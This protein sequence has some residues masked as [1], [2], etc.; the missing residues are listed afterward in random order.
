MFPR[1]AAFAAMLSVA[2][3]GDDEPTLNASTS[4]TT[5]GSPSTDTTTGTGPVST[6][7]SSST[8]PDAFVDTTAA[9]DSSTTAAP[10]DGVSA[11]FFDL[12]GTLVG[13]NPG[14]S[15]KFVERPGARALL[16]S[17]RDADIQLGLITT[18]PNNFTAQD[19]RD[20]L[21]EPDLLESFDLILMS[22]Q[23]AA[24]PK[25]DPAMFVEAHSL[26]RGAPAIEQ[27]AFITEE[28]ADIANTE[29]DPTLGAR[30]AGMLGVHLSDTT[31]S[32]LAD[33]TITFD[34]LLSTA[35]APWLGCP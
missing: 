8:G 24:S 5:T 4:T 2:C 7:S 9:L 34:S 20:L 27:T 3:G 18:V 16:D 13:D 10:C 12:G 1:A 31:P 35:E 6:G 25:P 23:A 17:L 32:A 28:L 19:L 33:Y 11:V 22:S 30:A 15:G 14:V 29:L 26:L 21:E